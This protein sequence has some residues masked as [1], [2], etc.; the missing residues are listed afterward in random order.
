[1]RK[2]ADKTDDPEFLASQPGK[3][4]MSVTRK[5]EYLHRLKIGGIASFAMTMSAWKSGALVV[6]S[7]LL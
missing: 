3:W 4:C 1:M 6:S 2:T 7:D 5:L